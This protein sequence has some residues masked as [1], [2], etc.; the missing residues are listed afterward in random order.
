MPFSLGNLMEAT[1]LMV[2]AIAILQDTS[3]SLKPGGPPVP[4]VLSKM[5]LTTADDTTVKGKIVTM[6]NAVRTL[7]RVPLI[8][9]NAIYVVY[10][11]L[12]G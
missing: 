11:L 5:G 10:L 9:I 2:N 4:R 12:V 7:L 6:M 1:L 8:A 3:P